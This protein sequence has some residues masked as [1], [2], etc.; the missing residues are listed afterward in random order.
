MSS[1]FPVC[2]L[3]HI[4]TVAANELLV[5]DELVTNRLL[6]V[7]GSRSELRDAVNHVTHQVEPIEFV[8]HTH[9]ERRARRT[10]FFIAAYVKIPVARSPVRK[11]VNQPGVAVEGED[12]WLVCSEQRVEIVIR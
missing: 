12:D 6:G 4:V 3:G 10:L 2:D 7:C 1:P 8:Q 11:P 5:L 9:V